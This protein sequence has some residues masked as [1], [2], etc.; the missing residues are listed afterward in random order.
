MAKVTC[1]I[2]G[3]RFACSYMEDLDL[4][5]TAGM[6]H[7]IFAASYKQLHRL[8]S[9]H[10]RGE[11]APKDSYLL[12]IA[13]LNTSEQ[14][15]WK[16]PVTLDPNDRQTKVLIENNLAQL[17]SVLEKTSVIQIP[18]FSQPSFSVNYENS[19][20]RTVSNWIKAWRDN[21]NN[22]Y[23]GRATDRE[24]DLLINAENRLTRMINSGIDKK[25]YSKIIA[26][27]AERAAEFP[28]NKAELYK[29]TICNCFSEAKMFNTSLHLLKEI[30]E[31]CHTHLELGSIHSYTL[32]SVLD[33]GIAKHTDYLGGS[34][35]ALGYELL[36]LN[37][38]S[39]EYLNDLK[40][41]KDNKEIGSTKTQLAIADIVTSAPD[42]LPVES[43]YSSK[44]AYIKAK[45]AYRTAANVNK[46]NKESL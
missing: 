10:C 20:L 45:L 14:V 40:A 34:S 26:N 13:F 37:K 21:I 24:R 32:F 36:D 28:A 2:S 44:L 27:W 16:H 18:T 11:L 4:P 38:A 31:H 46:Q 6:I 3:I 33:E 29:T 22:F 41:I 30:K 42:K 12:F 39:P 15:I 8:Y 43:D 17:V 9:K 7:P 19:D 35:L 25:A 5:H 1:A 23:N